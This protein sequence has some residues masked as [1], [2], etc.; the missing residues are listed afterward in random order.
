MTRLQRIL[1]LFAAI[2]ALAVLALMCS[3]LGK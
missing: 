2:F 3:I 1:Y